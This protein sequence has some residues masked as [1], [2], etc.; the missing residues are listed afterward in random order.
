MLDSPTESRLFHIGKAI[1]NE[2]NATEDGAVFA[3]PFILIGITDD[4]GNL[5][6][7]A[8]GAGIWVIKESKL[9]QAGQT[10]V[11]SQPQ[12]VCLLGK[13]P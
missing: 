8:A 5:L 9:L 1:K 6:Q 2:A 7:V 11:P 4:A 3:T 12:T 10:K 13:T